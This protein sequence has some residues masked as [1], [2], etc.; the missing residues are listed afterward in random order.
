[1]QILDAYG[2]AGMTYSYYDLPGELTGWLDGN[3]EPVEAGAVTLAAGEGLWVEAPSSAFT[4]QTAGQ[5][6]QTGY[7]VTL[8]KGSKVVINSSPVDVDLTDIDVTGY[9]AE[10]GTEADVKVQILDAY[11][12][13]GMTYSYYDLPGELTG[14]LDGNDDAV[15]TGAL[16][17]APGEGMWVEA[18]STAFS[19]VLPGVT[20]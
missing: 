18:P 3:D 9:D 5:V 4:L 20:L 16:V 2:M 17:I 10:A 8:R 14:W 1:M 11:G 19:L 12:M 7:L 15:E 6:P 13:A